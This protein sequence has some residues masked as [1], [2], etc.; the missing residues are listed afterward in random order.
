[1]A[2][3]IKSTA[4]LGTSNFS[5]EEIVIYTTQDR[6][7]RIIR[8]WGNPEREKRFPIP[9]WKIRQ[10]FSASSSDEVA[11]RINDINDSDYVDGRWLVFDGNFEED[12]DSSPNDNVCYFVLHEDF[13]YGPIEGP[14]GISLQGMFSNI[15]FPHQAII[16]GRIG[17]EEGGEYTVFFDIA[18]CPILDPGSAGGD[19]AISGA[20][21]PP[22]KPN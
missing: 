2:K 16:W 17:Q 13:F 11:L 18:N 19:G 3:I 15:E 10:L 4:V 14:N 9:I 22:P 6:E 12:I 20:K 21:I 5:S 8:Y 7:D 1:M